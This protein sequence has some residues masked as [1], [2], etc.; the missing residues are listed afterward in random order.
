[1]SQQS[2]ALQNKAAIIQ[3]FIA[4][5]I[6]G[7][8]QGISMLAIP[9]YFTGILGQTS[10]FGFI[11]FGVTIISLFWGLFA[12]TLVDRYNRKHL[13]LLETA[14]GALM[15]LGVAAFG[16][17][18]GNVPYYLVALIFGVT[19]WAYNLHYPALYAFVQE[20]SDPAHYGKLASWLEIQGQLTS[21]IAGGI[22]AILLSGITA[23]EQSFLGQ[24]W[25]IPFHIEAWSIQQVFLLD[26]L[27][28]ALSFL[29][30][31]PLRYKAIAIRKKETVSITARMKIGADYLRANPLIFVFINAAYF[32]FVT[33]M[34]INYILMPN[35][36][37]NYLH[38]GAS[39]YAI[40]DAAFA[41]GAL[42]SGLFI[43]RLFK[44]NN[45]VKGAIFMTFVSASAFLVLVFDRHVWVFCLMLL[46]FGLAN[47][48]SRIIRVSYIFRRVPNQVIGRVQSIFQVINV[49]F[50]LFFIAL[51]S[52]PFFVSH[53]SWAFGIF[54]AC[55]VVA[56]LIIIKIYKPL[57][58]TPT[59]NYHS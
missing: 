34:V 5:T 28:Y 46:F 57:T 7:F 20:I 54:S 41:I 31:L 53:I 19:F 6:S 49:L 10:L 30:I 26:G 55:C 58:S 29:L 13:F 16:F 32:I 59:T 17:Y 23:G 14:G 1:M 24:T 52:L 56:A 36:V 9:W 22:G 43:S 25:Y 38:S 45:L 39:V 21:A 4:N 37:K 40:A 44:D 8:A 50:R 27:T 2:P 18:T 11:Y 35:F 47:S 42:I 48:G 3:L 33:T 51:F 15:L 12:G